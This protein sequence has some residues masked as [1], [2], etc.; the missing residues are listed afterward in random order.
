MGAI[1]LVSLEEIRDYCFYIQDEMTAWRRYFH[2]NPELPW[3]EIR[4]S[5]RI[6]EE[7]NGFG[8]GNVA[9]GCGGKPVGVV[10]EIDS[11]TKGPCIAIRA[12]IDALP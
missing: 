12:D 4:T 5:S 3:E 2:A 11:G 7:L 10:A 8:I 6:A 9:V 1:F